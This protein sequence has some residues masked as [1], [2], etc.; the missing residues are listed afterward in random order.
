[1]RRIGRVGEAGH[2]MPV[3]YFKEASVEG[4]DFDRGARLELGAWTPPFGGLRMKLGGGYAVADRITETAG[5]GEWPCRVFRVEVP[6]GDWPV[7]EPNVLRVPTYR[8]IEELEGW[9]VLGPQGRE[10]SALLE[11][12]GRLTDTEVLNLASGE[13]DTWQPMED[14]ARAARRGTDAATDATSRHGAMMAV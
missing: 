8:P 7:V 1:M 12:A 14:R 5:K 4:R 13:G 9:R 10:V 3:E 6:E 2:G 11:R